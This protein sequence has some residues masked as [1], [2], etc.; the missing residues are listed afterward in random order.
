MV[1]HARLSN[2]L[3]AFHAVV[4]L[5][6]QPSQEEIQVWTGRKKEIPGLGGCAMEQVQICATAAMAHLHFIRLIRYKC[7]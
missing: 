1:T 2:L 7:L 4:W 3:L 5:T 6:E